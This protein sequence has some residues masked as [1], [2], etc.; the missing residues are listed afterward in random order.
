MAGRD[1]GVAGLEGSLVGRQRLAQQIAGLLQLA[2]VLEHQ[3]EIGLADRDGGVA[4][5]EG[6]LVGRQRLAQQ[7][8]GLLQLAQ[9]LEHQRE[10]G[11]ARRDLGV[12]WFVGGLGLLQAAPKRSHPEP[13]AAMI[14]VV[15]AQV[16]PQQ[17]SASGADL[18]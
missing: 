8:A 16:V 14:A 17:L 7:V 10:I 3:R 5:L 12:A 11:L 1:G 6:S 15:L 2:Q 4:G 18:V 13:V 9:V